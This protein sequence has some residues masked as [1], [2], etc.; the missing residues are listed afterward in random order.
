MC[1]DPVLF[2]PYLRFEGSY[3]ILKVVPNTRGTLLPKRI[4]QYYASMLYT[5]KSR[6][7]RRGSS[8]SDMRMSSVCKKKNLIRKRK[9]KQTLVSVLPKTQNGLNYV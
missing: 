7:E 9:S 2:C 8:R 3:I 1:G 6:Q 4:T 5:K